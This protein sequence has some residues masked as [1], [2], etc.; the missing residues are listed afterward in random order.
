MQ[1]LQNRIEMLEILMT[2]YGTSCHVPSCGFFLY[3]HTPTQAAAPQKHQ[4]WATCSTE[5]L[6]AVLEG[7]VQLRAG[8]SALHA[9]ENHTNQTNKEKGFAD[10]LKQRGQHL[11]SPTKVGFMGSI[12]NSV[13][14]NDTIPPF[15]G[16]GYV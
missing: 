1:K 5:P 10:Q 2:K 13:I 4:C 3:P 14:P 9:G 6:Q 15:L 7:P 11:K 8:I 16:P 12:Q